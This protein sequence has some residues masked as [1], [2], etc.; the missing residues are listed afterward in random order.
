MNVWYKF[1]LGLYNFNYKVML[2]LIDKNKDGK[3]SDEEW[4]D[5]YKLALKGFRIILKKLKSL[6][7]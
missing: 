5:A 4:A 6:K 2:Y 7:N 3:I 1:C